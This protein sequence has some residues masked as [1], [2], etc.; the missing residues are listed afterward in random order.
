[1][2]FNTFVIAGPSTLTASVVNTV[3]G[4]VAPGGAVSSSLATQCQTDTF[5]ITG[6]A[7]GNPPVICGTN[8]GYHGN[9]EQ[10]NYI[11]LYKILSI[12]L[13]NGCK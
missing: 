13:K 3:G 5:S 9:L 6:T 8:T 12:R 1:M 11:T 4:S 10:K 2:D 7:G